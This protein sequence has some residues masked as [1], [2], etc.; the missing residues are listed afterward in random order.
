MAV[1]FSADGDF[2]STSADTALCLYRVA[3]EGLRNV[4]THANAG[5]AEVRLFRAG[6]VAELYHRR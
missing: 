4:V 5:R 1:T 3:Q 2:A 6:D